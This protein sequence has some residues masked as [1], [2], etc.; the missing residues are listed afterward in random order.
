M[1]GTARLRVW[2]LVI[3]IGVALA[4]SLWAVWPWP[5]GDWKGLALNF[6]TEMA[7]A[8]VTYALLELFIGRRERREAEEEELAAKKA[9]LIA[10]MGS[11]VPGV[12]I[13]AAE[14][15]RRH[16]WHRDGS[17][18]GAFLPGATLPG[19]NLFNADLQGA[20]LT[21]AILQQANLGRANLQGAFLFRANLK[22]ANLSRANL[23]KA[24]LQEADLIWANLQGA[25]LAG[26]SLQGARLGGA[27]L[28]EAYLSEADL[29]EAH[30]GGADLQEA[31]LTKTNL[32]GANLS[33]ANLLGAGLVNAILSE[34]T[35]L[36]DGTKWTPN[37]AMARFTD[38]DHPDFWRPDA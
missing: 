19:V 32:Q 15:L 34:D 26:A 9:D 31:C 24:N 35:T 37:T 5:T 22:K 4:S 1:K 10:K 30:L 17:L 2:V 21:V 14:E 27:N 8:V 16:D 25:N 7:G 23:Q 3:L 11:Q 29:Q 20:H 38:P 28:Q 33:K 18:R 6:G 13:A 12:A 36:P